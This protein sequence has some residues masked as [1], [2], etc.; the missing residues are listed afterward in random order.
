MQ[1]PHYYTARQMQGCLAQVIPAWFSDGLTDEEVAHF[2]TITLADAQVWSK[3]EDLVLVADGQERVRRIAEGVSSALPGGKAEVHLLL[4]RQILH[5][6]LGLQD[7]PVGR[8]EKASLP[9]VSAPGV[10]V[11]QG[12]HVHPVVVAQNGFD[13]HRLNFVLLRHIRYIEEVD[14]VLA[15]IGAQGFVRGLYRKLRHQAVQSSFAGHI[16]AGLVVKAVVVIR[17]EGFVQSR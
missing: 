9:S 15:A 16:T 3:P 7:G 13:F 5:I 12:G 1:L 4:V 6:A 17:K 14:Q 11:G 10:D 8:A 2:L